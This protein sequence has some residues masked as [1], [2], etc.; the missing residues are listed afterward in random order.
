MGNNKKKVMNMDYQLNDND[1]AK[2]N[3]PGEKCI[4]VPLCLPEIP[5]GLD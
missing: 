5:H 2:Q 4:L 3:V 1:W